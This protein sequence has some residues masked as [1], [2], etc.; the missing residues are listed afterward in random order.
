MDI[1]WQKFATLS[2]LLG[3]CLEFFIIHKKS[4]TRLDLKKYSFAVIRKTLFQTTQ[5]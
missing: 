5:P 2:S 3:C 4:A 1:D